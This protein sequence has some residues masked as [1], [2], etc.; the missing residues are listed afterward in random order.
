MLEADGSR[1][2]GVL[3]TGAG[4]NVAL[5][6]PG[7]ELAVVYGWFAEP[8]RYLIFGALQGKHYQCFSWDAAKGD[9]KAVCPEGIFDSYNIFLSPDN[10]RVISPTPGGWYAYSTSGGS[11]SEVHG[12]HD[13]EFPIGWRAGSKSISFVSAERQARLSRSGL[14]ISPTA[15]GRS[16]RNSAP[17]APLTAPEICTSGSH[18]TAAHMRTITQSSFLICTWAGPQVKE[19]P[20]VSFAPSGATSAAPWSRFVLPALC[21]GS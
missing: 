5:R 15:K 10:T 9:L 3:P 4:E 13:D 8:Q 1:A 19:F 17:R 12:I 7:T 20:F 11:A 14:W 16:G 2:F 21:T 6:V 18:P